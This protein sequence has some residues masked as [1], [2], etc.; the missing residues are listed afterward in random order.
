MRRLEGTTRRR[1]RTLSRHQQAA[2]RVSSTPSRTASEVNL[3]WTR[4]PVVP[5]AS[6]IRLNI[7]DTGSK[8]PDVV[9]SQCSTLALVLGESIKPPDQE[10]YAQL[11]IRTSCRLPPTTAVSLQ[12]ALGVIRCI[13][14]TAREGEPITKPRWPVIIPRTLKVPVVWNIHSV[15]ESRVYRAW[16]LPRST[17]ED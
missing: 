7:L 8:V 3:G 6:V 5:Q 10:Y 16:V 4:P 11:T 14:K 1:P 17:R 9:R 15:T 12:W 13:K 2:K